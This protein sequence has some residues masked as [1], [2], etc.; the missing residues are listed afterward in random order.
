MRRVRIQKLSRVALE[1]I[2]Q[3]IPAGVVVIEKAHG[4]VSYVNDRAIELYG[5]D[6]RGLE[7][8]NH[9]TKLMK[10]L[11]LDGDVYPPEKLPAKHSSSER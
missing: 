9:S 4:Q 1:A 7:L 3:S 11:T 2:V 6:P 5:V 8:P 10:L